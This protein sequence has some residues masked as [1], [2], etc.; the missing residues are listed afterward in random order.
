MTKYAN[1]AHI[2]TGSIW[3]PNVIFSHHLCRQATDV[4]GLQLISL[5]QNRGKLDIR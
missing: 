1:A 2:C 3:L 5:P 4:D